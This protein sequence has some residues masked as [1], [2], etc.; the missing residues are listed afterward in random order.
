MVSSCRKRDDGTCPSASA[1]RQCTVDS[2][3]HTEAEFLAA[4]LAGNQVSTGK[5]EVINLL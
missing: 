3:N 1:C 2:K 5:G 4:V